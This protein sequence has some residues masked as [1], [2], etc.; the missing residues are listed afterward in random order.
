MKKNE[1]DCYEVLGYFF[2]TGEQ[3]FLH[4]RKMCYKKKTDVEIYHH[5]ITEKGYS[6]NNR[7]KI[8]K[9]IYKP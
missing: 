1:I 7:R 8:T 5:E 6:K 9:L 3:A 4:A 2:P